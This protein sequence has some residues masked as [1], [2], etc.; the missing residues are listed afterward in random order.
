MHRGRSNGRTKVFQ[1]FIQ[2]RPKPRST[3]RNR[4]KLSSRA[5]PSL[6]APHPRLRPTQQ[7]RPTKWSL[8]LKAARNPYRNPLLAC[9]CSD[10][11]RL[12]ARCRRC[13]K[14]VSARCHCC[15]RTGVSGYLKPG[16]STRSRWIGCPPGQATFLG[17]RRTTSA[18]KMRGPS[19]GQNQLPCRYQTEGYRTHTIHTIIQSILTHRV[20][21]ARIHGTCTRTCIHTQ[22]QNLHTCL[23]ETRSS[24][25]ARRSCR[26]RGSVCCC[27][28]RL[29]RHVCCIPPPAPGPVLS[30]E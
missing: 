8:L 12:A 23:G 3:S 9:Y 16:D 26:A 18:R 24:L 7:W 25:V 6:L 19:G 4:P 10:Q 20:R 30:T 14:W 27:V 15:Q 21:A 11:R 2:P 1:R 17:G 5:R 13:Q 29:A 22:C 28:E